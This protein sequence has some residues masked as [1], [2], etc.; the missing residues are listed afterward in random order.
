[1]KI[2]LIK[3]KFNGTQSYKYKPFKYCCE[4]IKDNPIITLTA[5]N[6]VDNYYDED[7]EEYNSPKFCAT[8]NYTLYDYSDEW[9]EADN[10]PIQYCPFCGEKIEFSVIKE[11]D[12]NEKYEE[13]KRLRDKVCKEWRETDSKEK[14]RKLEKQ[15]LELDNEINEMYEFTEYNAGIEICINKL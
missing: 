11:E 7:N 8:H 10:Y 12:L 2:E 6:I 13:L 15:L 14:S 3:Q 4:T 5:E 1:M 9:N